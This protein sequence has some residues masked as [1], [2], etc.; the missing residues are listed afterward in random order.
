MSPAEATAAIWKLGGGHLSA[1]DGVALRGSE[2]A[3][4]S[5]FA[6]GTLAQAT[7]A[8]SALAAA[9]LWS[10]RTGRRQLAAVDMR[11]AVAE[12][13]SERYLK[14]EGQPE[15]RIWDKVA[16]VY[17]TGD[18]RYVRIHANMPHHRARTLAFLGADYDRESVAA[19]LQGWTGEALET[20]AAE[21]GM[22]ITM[23][24]SL[25]EWRAHPQGQAVSGL[26]LFEIVK[27][28]DAAPRRRAAAE[29]PLSGLRVL[30]LTR[31][32]AG[33]VCGRTLA[34]H[35]AD[36]LSVTGPGIPDIETLI[37]DGGRGKLRTEIDLGQDGGRETLR[38]LA[39]QADVFVQGYRPGAIAAKGFSPEQ[40]AEISPG[41]V[42]VSLSAWGHAGPWAGR[43]GFDSLVQNANGLNHAEAAAAGVAGPKE[44][45]CQALDHGTGMLMAAGA[46]IALRRQAEEGGSWL[47]RVS[48]AQTGEW[49][50]RLGRL[51]TGLAV[52]EQTREDIVDLLETTET[53]FGRMSAVRHSGLL[54]ESPPHHSRPAVALGTHP[55]HWPES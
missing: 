29:R 3:L 14:V 9:E 41:I 32:I 30:D 26:P 24:R 15:R 33:P 38:T 8:A 45:P 51:E 46:M 44:L 42:C 22:V 52:P 10:L 28:G 19:K 21:N 7:V 53:P 2:P 17:Q 1:L 36:V 43:R 49:L 16:G 13:R 54:S 18:G 11:H 34:A 48:L 20:A 37:M 31:V 50:T 47:V 40:V 25:E 12:F 23:M 6:V 35:G 27:I 4:P 39:R 5:T 55:A